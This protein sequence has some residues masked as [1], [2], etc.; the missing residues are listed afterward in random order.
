MSKCKK[1]SAFNVFVIRYLNDYINSVFKLNRLSYY[2]LLFNSKKN[3][4]V[5]LNTSIYLNA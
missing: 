4:A 2:A 3:H 1:T 5:E